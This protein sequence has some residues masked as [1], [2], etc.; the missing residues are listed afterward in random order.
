MEKMDSFNLSR[1][2]IDKLANQYKNIQ[3]SVSEIEGDFRNLSQAK[4]D[5]LLPLNSSWSL[6]YEMPYLLHLTYL[7]HCMGIKDELKKALEHEDPKGET[8]RVIDN[9]SD[10]DIDD[11]AL[12]DGV[13]PQLL[14]MCWYSLMKSLKSW[15]VYGFTLSKLLEKVREGSYKSLFDAVQIDPTFIGCPSALHLMSRGILEKRRGFTKKLGEAMRSNRGKYREDLESFRFILTAM[16]ES[17]DLQTL[18]NNERYKLFCEDM[19]VYSIKDKEDPAEAMKKF[20][21]RWISSAELYG[22]ARDMKT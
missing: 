4:W 19:K 17:G 22:D 15:M 9:I 8:L 11:I 21:Y 2:R 14:F 20:I 18:T 12:P 3:D 7:L 6:F 10:R 5:K 16:A 13:T 1:S